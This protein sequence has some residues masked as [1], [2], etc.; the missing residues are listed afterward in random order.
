MH[1]G[2]STKEPDAGL[3]LRT[4]SDSWHRLTLPQ[5]LEERKRQWTLGPSP[6]LFAAAGDAWF[7]AY[8]VDG[9][10]ARKSTLQRRILYRSR[11]AA[12]FVKLGAPK[13][14]WVNLG[15]PVSCTP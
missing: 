5:T 13:R 8:Y 12:S 9:D 10:P 15:A 3:W 7:Q 4:R 2:V 6:G 1:D 14:A 11:A